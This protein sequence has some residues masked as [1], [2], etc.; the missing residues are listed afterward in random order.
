MALSSAKRMNKLPRWLSGQ[1]SACQYLPMSETQIPNITL[2]TYS[3]IMFG[4][5]QNNS[6]IDFI[7]HSMCLVYTSLSLRDI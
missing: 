7:F 6:R 4:I 5:F 2:Y 1:E 3:P